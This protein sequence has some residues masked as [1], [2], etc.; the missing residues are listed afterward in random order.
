MAFTGIN[1]AEQHHARHETMY[2]PSA[3]DTEC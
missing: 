2:Q 3:A 1:G